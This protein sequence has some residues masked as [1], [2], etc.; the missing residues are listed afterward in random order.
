L[1]YSKPQANILK[2]KYKKKEVYT[3]PLPLIDFGKMPIYAKDSTITTF[4]F[5][6]NI[7]HYKGLDILLNSINRLSNEYSNFK[8][9][10]AG[11]CADWNEIYEPLIQ[12][13][14]V[15]SAHIGFSENEDIPAFFAQAD[16]LVLPYRDTTQSSPLMI[17]YNYNI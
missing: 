12:H 2:E 3:I 1:T 15:V 9:I 7:L 6:G 10:I 5:F 4:L 13:K 8:L 17:A 16:Y 14:K 11:R